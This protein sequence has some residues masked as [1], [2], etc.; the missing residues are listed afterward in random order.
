MAAEDA[1]ITFNGNKV[2]VRV[3]E[4]DT[5]LKYRVFVIAS[6]VTDASFTW[7]KITPELSQLGCMTVIMDLPGFGRSDC[8]EDVPQDPQTRAQIGWGII[9]EV[10]SAIGGGDATWHIMAHGTAC[11]TALAMANMYP[12]SVSSMVYISPMMNTENGI[13][14]GFT[15]HSRWFDSNIASPAGY[16]SLLDKLFARHPDDYV[17]DS[18]RAQFRRPG[19]KESFVNMLSQRTKPEPNKGFAPAMTLWGEKDVLM[20]EKTIAAF[21]K[22]VPESEI[23]VM[24]TAGHMPM[25]THSHAMR[26]YLRGWIKYVG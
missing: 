13:R 6:P 16:R 3:V 5:E 1:F 20:D 23:H 25:E 8:G 10:D 19:A 2:H 26:D 9:D 15:S 11:Q 7:R 17:T 22:L 12:D 14:T 24:K 4:P 18:M 21:K